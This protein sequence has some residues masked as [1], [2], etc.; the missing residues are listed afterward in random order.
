M[1]FELSFGTQNSALELSFGTL[2][3][4]TLTL[5]EEDV[6]DARPTADSEDI[7]RLK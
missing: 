5:L 2:T 6:G 4:G 7:D 3:F 1:T